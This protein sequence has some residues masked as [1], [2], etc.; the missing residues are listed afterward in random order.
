MV[1]YYFYFTLK[2]AQRT[3]P[4]IK[5]SLNVVLSIRGIMLK[6]KICKKG[7]ENFRIKWMTEYGIKC[8]DF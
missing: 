2:T 7:Q 6:C 8:T 4:T 1:L 5:W 3:M